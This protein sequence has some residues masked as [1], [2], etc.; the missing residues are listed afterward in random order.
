MVPRS[1]NS[2]EGEFAH[3]LNLADIHS[4][5]K[6]SRALLGKSQVAVQQALDE[7]EGVLP[8]RLLGVGSDKGLEFINWHLKR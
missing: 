3:S 6:E 1:G 8:F 2:S 5:W 4:G 7:V